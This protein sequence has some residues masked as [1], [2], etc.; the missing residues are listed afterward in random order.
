MERNKTTGKR[1][2]KPGAAGIPIRN[3]VPDRLDL[4]DRLYMPPVSVVPD[5]AFNPKTDIP[6]LNQGQTNACT[7]FALASVVYHVQYASKRK[8]KDCCVSP[9]MLYSMARRYDEFPGAPDVDTGSSLRGAMKGWYKHGACSDRLWVSEQMPTGSMTKSSDDWWLDAV[10]RPLGAYYRVDPRSVTDMHVALNE[11]GILYASAV[12]HSGWNEGFSKTAQ[13][14]GRYWTIP[15]QKASPGDGGHAFAFVGYNQD[16]FIVHNSWGTGWGT[17]GRAVLPYE[18]WLDHAMDCWVAQLG[19][20]TDL[21]LEI[22]HSTTL[23]VRAGKVQLAGESSL[24]TREIS[25]FIVDMENNGLL[26]NTGDF[27]T[28]ESD[29]TA[30]VT[31]HL[32]KA[33]TA[34]GLGKNDPVDIAIYA[35]GGLTSEDDA[36]DTAAKW[37]MAL[38]EHKIFPIF[39]MWETD[40]WSTL[41]GRLED[42][43]KGQLRPTGGF[44]DSAKNWWN[45]RLEKLLAAPGT[46]I[47]SEMK[48][49]ADAISN[50]AES[51]GMK[52]Y[53]ACQQSPYFADLSKVRLHL[54]GHS[55]GSILHSH[56][57]QRLGGQGW[58]FESVNFL[59]PAVRVDL[60]EKAVLPAIKDGRVK[61][62]NQ[63]HLSDDMEQKDPT[64]TPILG[65]SRSLLYLVSQS[66]EQGKRTP[67]LGLEKY[68]N[69]KIAAK[70][71]ANVFTWAA[72]G[73][74]SKSTTHG[75][76]DDDHVTM[77]SVIALMKGKAP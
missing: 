52:L 38:Y 47:W 35:H 71:L 66:L 44:F 62:F 26:S 43:V 45:E 59:A 73:K 69:D 72:P 11:I 5:L 67:I 15:G 10:Q 4:R 76:F 74:E 16:G 7:G 30:L 46:A 6:V 31:H 48:Q 75:G 33:R 41:R 42:L 60:F 55:A 13:T 27:R 19:V 53:R 70:Q 32:G 54:V 51:G 37:I 23:R 9:F 14:K 25:P 8:H 49:N 68:F 64:C 40:L 3:V 29:V 65:Y 77:M 20:V 34:W 58:T 36:G 2:K 63:F 50:R 28:Q 17:K 1:G 61:R 24:R 57:V 18:D 56:G 21:H 39:L 12:C 22:A